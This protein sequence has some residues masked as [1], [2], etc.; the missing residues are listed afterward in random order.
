MTFET[1]IKHLFTGK[2]NETVDIGRVSW[3]ICL[4][5]VIGFAITEIVKVE[6]FNLMEFA[7]SIAAVVGVHSAGIWAKRDTE[8]EPQLTDQTTEDNK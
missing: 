6:K 4:F 2:D 1:I 8:P 5:A 3:A 7:Q